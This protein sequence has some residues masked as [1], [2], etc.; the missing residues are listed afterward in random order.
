[1]SALNCFAMT[2]P[3]AAACGTRPDPRHRTPQRRVWDALCAIPTGSTVTHAALA[4]RIGEPNAVR[5]VANACAAN[6]IALAIPYH[7][8]ILSERDALRLPLGRRA[9]ADAAGAQAQA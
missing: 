9:Q 7:R 4:R 5:A 8:V 1:M 2:T 3:C 6:A